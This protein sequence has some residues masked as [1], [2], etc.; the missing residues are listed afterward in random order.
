MRNINRQAD[1]INASLLGD[2][3]EG[4]ALGLGFNYSN[5]FFVNEQ[6]VIGVAGFQRVLAHGDSTAG[7]QV[8]IYAI[9]NN[10][11]A[12]GKLAVDILTGKRFG[13]G[14]SGIGQ[15]R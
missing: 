5:C 1:G 3:G 13:G 9:L 14:H 15:S 2:R 8:H 7:K 10:P 4:S 6:Q 12:G 11:A